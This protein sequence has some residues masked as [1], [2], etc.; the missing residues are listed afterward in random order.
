MEVPVVDEICKRENN[1]NEIYR[2]PHARIRGDSP[3]HIHFPALKLEKYKTPETLLLL[4]VVVLIFVP[5]NAGQARAD[6]ATSPMSFA[7]SPPLSH[8]KA[9]K[10]WKFSIQR[11]PLVF[12]NFQEIVLL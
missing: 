12:V 9:E 3:Q 5:E 6:A 7:E 11:E 8:K 10:S 2:L 4:K 1:G